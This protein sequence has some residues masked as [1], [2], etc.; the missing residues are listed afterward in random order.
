[1]GHRNTLSGHIQEAW[2]VKG[3]DRATEQL[4]HHNR[5]VLESLPDDAEEQWPY[6]GKRMF[7][8]SPMF[9]GPYTGTLVPTYRGPVIYFGGSF[10]SIYQDWPEWLAKFENLLRQLYWE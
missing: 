7:S 3:S 8:T 10:S 9:T 5:R 4:W 6:L 1:M 2:Y